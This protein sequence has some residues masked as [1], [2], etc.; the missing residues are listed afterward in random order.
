MEFTITPSSKQVINTIQVSYNSNPED[1]V[2][3]FFPMDENYNSSLKDKLNSEPNSL[4]SFISSR[5]HV[6]VGVNITDDMMK[7]N[8]EFNVVPTTY[9]DIISIGMSLGINNASMN[10]FGTMLIPNFIP[11]IKTSGGYMEMNDNN[12]AYIR[13][14][15]ILSRVIYLTIIALPNDTIKTLNDN[16]LQVHIDEETIDFAV[17]FFSRVRQVR[18]S[19]FSNH[20][21]ACNSLWCKYLTKKEAEK[22]AKELLDIM[23]MRR[24]IKYHNGFYSLVTP[25]TFIGNTSLLPQSRHN[26]KNAFQS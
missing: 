14:D 23:I 11:K 22:K 18:S 1:V 9:V 4:F 13:Q 2:V 12:L 24:I 16:K 5:K 17:L 10:D 7:I 19:G 6:K 3:V 15:A 26:S 8:N 21:H 25:K 20:M